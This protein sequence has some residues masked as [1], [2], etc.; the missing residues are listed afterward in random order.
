MPRTKYTRKT[1]ANDS[2]KEY[3]MMIQTYD[4]HVQTRIAKLERDAQTEVKSFETFVDVMVNRIPTE[5]RQMTLSKI[6]VWQNGDK[7]KE[8]YNNEVN[9][10]DNN[11]MQPPAK[12]KAKPKTVNKAMK[13]LTTAISDDGYATEGGTSI[14]S[15]SKSKRRT[16]VTT[17]RKTRSSTM[18]SKA[19]LMEIN[20]FKT[21]AMLKPPPN[22]YDVVTPKI[23]P[24]T[25]LNVLRRP[26]QGEMVLSMK[27]SPLLVSA[28]VEEKTANINVP[29]ADGNVMSLLP[30]EGLRMSHI[31]SL[32]A[33]TMLQLQT[34]KNHIEKVIS[35]K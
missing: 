28:I 10:F 13:R 35:L 4:R 24:N 16:Q 11:C 15:T 9:S 32:D 34:L 7:Q 30:Q 18:A 17:T 25:P 5:I 1:K 3:N 26:R 23:K 29:L 6:L 14:G 19:K 33:E 31:P 8:N 22:V 12:P 27:G 20:H 21:P 2:I